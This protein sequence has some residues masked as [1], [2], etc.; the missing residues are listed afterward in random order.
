[1]GKGTWKLKATYTPHLALT[2]QPVFQITSCTTPPTL[3]P[4]PPNPRSHISPTEY[5]STHKPHYAHDSYSSESTRTKTPPYHISLATAPRPTTKTK[6]RSDQPR[7]QIQTHPTF[8][9]SL[10]LAD[11]QTDPSTIRH[12][13]STI[14]PSI[15]PSIDAAD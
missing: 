11:A 9:S 3:Q 14:H 6:T 15:H 13:D 7:H 10:T 2:L 12:Q 8:R 4:A 1:M 5:S